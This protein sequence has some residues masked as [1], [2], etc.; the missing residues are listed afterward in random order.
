MALQTAALL[1]LA[2]NYAGDIVRQINRRSQTLALLR[3]VAGE[4]KNIAWAAESDGANAEAF[5]EGADA[6]NFAAD[7]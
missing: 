6:A 1:I 5:A 4:G 2:Q 7:A 3:K